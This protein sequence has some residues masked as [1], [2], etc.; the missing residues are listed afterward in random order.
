M[1]AALTPGERVEKGQRLGLITW[2]SQT[3][4]VLE[5]D[6]PEALEVLVEEGDY[7]Y[8]GSTILVRHQAR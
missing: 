1:V 5:S 4:L 8:G 6:D 2:G 3:D 7:V